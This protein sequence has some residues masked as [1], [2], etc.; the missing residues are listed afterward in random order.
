[1]KIEHTFLYT[2]EYI[3]KLILGLFSTSTQLEQQLTDL[4]KR[5]YGT[6]YSPHEDSLD[7]EDMRRLTQWLRETKKEK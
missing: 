3:Y 6:V 1:M 5:K 2:I 4:M 7:I